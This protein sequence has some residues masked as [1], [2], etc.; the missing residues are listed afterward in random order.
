[1]VIMTDHKVRNPPGALSGT[2]FGKKRYL[3]G[4]IG[5]LSREKYTWFDVSH[6]GGLSYLKSGH[7][8]VIF[9]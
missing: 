6:I 7:F 5:K 4:T 9:D 2:H 3:T 1:M 8:F